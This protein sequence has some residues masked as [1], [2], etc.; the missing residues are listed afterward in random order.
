MR[1]GGCGLNPSTSFPQP[2]TPRFLVPHSQFSSLLSHSPPS[3][4]LSLSPALA[5][6]PS[7]SISF[8]IRSISHTCFLIAP[9]AVLLQISNEPKTIIFI[10]HPFRF[11]RSSLLLYARNFAAPQ[12]QDSYGLQFLR[13]GNGKEPNGH[14]QGQRCGQ[15]VSLQGLKRHADFHH[16]RPDTS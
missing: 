15:C 9:S 8:A 14:P 5:L 6:C 4:F 1:S 10:K 13:T 3:P 7:V 11:S 2:F 16:L 12:A